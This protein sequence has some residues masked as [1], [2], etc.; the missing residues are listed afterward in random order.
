M[1]LSIFL[2]LNQNSQLGESGIWDKI[3]IS[4]VAATKA[5]VYFII[6][7]IPYLPAGRHWIKLC[8]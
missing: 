8:D 5:A 3:C 6:I 2:N 4:L 1:R 7:T